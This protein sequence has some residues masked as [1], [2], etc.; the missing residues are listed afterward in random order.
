MSSQGGGSTHDLIVESW[1]MYGVGILFFILRLY[2]RYKRMKFHFQVEDYMMFLAIIFYTAF[3]VTNIEITN[4]GSTLYEPGQ[5]ETFTAY[6]IQQRVLGSKIEFASENCQVCTV[7]CLKACMLLVYFRIT[8]NLKQHQW[9]KL[10]AVYTALGWLATELTLFLNCHPVSGYWTLPPPQRQ[11]ATY[12]NFEI[13]Q[14]VFNISSDVTILLVV[15]PLLFRARMPWRT[16]LPI[17][18]VFSMG[19]VV[20]LCA[21]ISKIFTFRSIFNTSY[22]FWYL[23]E[24]SIGV[25]VTNAPSVWSLARSTITFLKSTSS[26]TK[27]TPGYNSSAPGI[28]ASR[29]RTGTETP[30]S[31]ALSRMYDMEHHSGSEE[32]IIEMDERNK[33]LYTSAESIDDSAPSASDWSGPTHEN[34]SAGEQE[35]HIW[36]TTEITIQKS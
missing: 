5:F 15:L 24:A 19:I 23:R 9:V 25:W 16:K 7:Y 29:A 27:S 14:A 31:H 4:Y 11:C 13:V 3:V 26:P 8:S 20:I 1:I 21:I 34:G 12:L 10:C 33:A 2:A 22:Q 32:A 18:V 6:D 17:V 30:S 36:K 28:S 35:G